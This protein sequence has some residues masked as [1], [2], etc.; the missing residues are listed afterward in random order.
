MKPGHPSSMRLQNLTRKLEFSP[1]KL[2]PLALSALFLPVVP[3][4]VRAQNTPLPGAGQSESKNADVKLPDFDV[5]SVKENKGE[6]HMMRWMSTADR[7]SITNLSL[8]NILTSAYNIKQY[9]I[10]GGPSWVYSTSFDVDAKVDAADVQTFKKLSPAQHRLMLQKLL[11]DRFHL[12]VHIET[13]MLPVYDLVVAS[14]GSKLKASAPDPPPPADANP[15]DPPKPR[16][17]MRMGA[18]WLE[19]QDTPLG[20]FVEQLSYSVNRTVI[21]KTG[22]SGKYDLT[23]KWTPDDQEPADDSSDNQA[24]HLFTALQEQLGLKLEP[25]KG[26]VDTLVIDHVEMPTAN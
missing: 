18:G 8:A 2:L 25:S 21:N 14:G 10:S 6:D 9:L 16:G 1:G 13:K 12:A 17:M 22:L 3:A 5:V 4:I 20:T 7:I 15:S 19:L 24:P 23:L 11:A 26:P